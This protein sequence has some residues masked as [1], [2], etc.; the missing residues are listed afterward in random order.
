MYK[1][2]AITY[3]YSARIDMNVQ[4]MW[5]LLQVH[6]RIYSESQNT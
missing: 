3:D 6:Q 4:F 1:T 2:D 5:E